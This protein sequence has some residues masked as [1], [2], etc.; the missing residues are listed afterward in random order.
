MTKEH[1]K[2]EKMIIESSTLMAPTTKEAEIQESSDDELESC[3]T[4]FNNFKERE[5][6]PTCGRRHGNY[7]SRCERRGGKCCPKWTNKRIREHNLQHG[8]APK[9]PIAFGPPQ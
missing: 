4:F 1:R 5:S 6:C 7:P 9:K 2:Q 3:K 8:D